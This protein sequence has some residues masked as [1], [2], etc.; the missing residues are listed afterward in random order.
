[1]FGQRKTS[2]FRFDLPPVDA[3]LQVVDRP[4]WIGNI[5]GH[6]DFLRE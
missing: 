4:R 6:D 5:Q 1:V 3:D 2:E